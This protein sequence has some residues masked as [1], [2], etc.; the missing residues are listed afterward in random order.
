MYIQVKNFYSI[1]I[2]KLLIQVNILNLIWYINTNLTIICVGI[3]KTSCIVVVGD[4]DDEHVKVQVD[5]KDDVVGKHKEFY[6][7]L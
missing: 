4:A 6:N 7:V 2:S 3:K 5:G 1:L